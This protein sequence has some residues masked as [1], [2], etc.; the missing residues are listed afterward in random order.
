[1]SPQRQGWRHWPD[2]LRWIGCFVLVLALHATAAAALIGHWRTEDEP[3]TKGPVILI[4]LAPIEAAPAKPPNDV[5][6]APQPEQ[7]QPTPQPEPKPEKAEKAEK[8]DKPDKP[9]VTADIKTPQEQPVEKIAPAPVP[10]PLPPPAETPTV[11]KDIVMPPPRPAKEIKAQRHRERRLA[12]LTPEPTRTEHKASRAMAPHAGARAHNPNAVPRWKT[13]L[14]ERLQRYKRYPPAAQA[15]G[16]QGVA[17]LAFS[18]DRHGGV[19]HARIVR[20]SG[21]SLLDHATMQLI[22]RAQPLPP[23]PPEVQGTEIAIVVPIR[24]NLR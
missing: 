20:S 23:P 24:Y 14:V 10:V 19:H 12:K 16:V 7:S 2:G 5:A 15:S 22:E 13:A 11:L 6:P 3:V 17:Q 4:D 8:T 9:V 21:S 1:M 18:V